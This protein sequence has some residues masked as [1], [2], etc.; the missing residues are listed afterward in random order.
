ME[1]A[2]GW[3]RGDLALA[4][5]LKSSGTGQT[6]CDNKIDAYFGWVSPSTHPRVISDLAAHL[7]NATGPAIEGYK[8]E[9]VL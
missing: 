6:V 4:T 3:E 9:L 8:E 1:A 5:E 7:V 2:L